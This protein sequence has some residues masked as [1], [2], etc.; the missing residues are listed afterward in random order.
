MTKRTVLLAPLFVLLAVHVVSC[1]DE[2][3]EDAV[4]PS[5][6]FTS[7]LSGQI[8]MSELINEE[9]NSFCDDYAMYTLDR[10]DGDDLTR[11]AC[12][13]GAA[14]LS[15]SDDGSVDIASCSAAAQS[16]LDNGG[17]GASTE[18]STACKRAPFRQC[19]APVADLETC[20]TGIVQATLALAPDLTCRT[21]SDPITLNLLTSPPACIALNTKCPGF[22]TGSVQ[23]TNNSSSNSFN[24]SSNSSSN[25]STIPRNFARVT[26][27][28]Q[29]FS[30]VAWTA[31]G[32]GGEMTVTIYLDASG[33]PSGDNITFDLS[34]PVLPVTQDMTRPVSGGSASAVLTW[35][36]S[37]YTN[38]AGDASV[39]TLY[40]EDHPQ[41]GTLVNFDG[42]VTDGSGSQVTV[43][44]MFDGF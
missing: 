44:S 43:S 30:Q 41:R 28:G 8:K 23:S 2:D 29:T 6:P 16:C 12:Y 34:F 20:Y 37:T 24:N 25:N 17:V 22:L 33:D 3:A 18:P 11:I 32:V 38:V 36:G 10:L 19:D 42:V 26:L 14:A 39:G 40:F 4:D 21:F 5:A 1:G 31:G 7:G 35:Q 27:N 13:G 9:I 15:R